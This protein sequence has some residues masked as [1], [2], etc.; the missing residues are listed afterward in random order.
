M[1]NVKIFKFLSFAYF[2]YVMA[3]LVVFVGDLQQWWPNLWWF[4]PSNIDN[5]K[6][7]L[8][9][10][11][12]T[13]AVIYDCILLGVF[14]AQH[15]GMATPEFKQWAS[16][17]VSP[18]LERS[19]YVLASSVV[20]HALMMFWIP[21]AQPILGWSF[22]IFSNGAFYA[23]MIGWGIMLASLATMD[24][25]NRYGV[26]EVFG[27]GQTQTG[28]FRRP[29]LH[30]FVRQP[31]FLGFL[32]G[33][34]SCA[35]MTHGHLLF[36]L[37]MTAYSIYGMQRIEK[38]LVNQYGERYTDFQRNTGLLFPR[39]GTILE[40]ATHAPPIVPEAHKVHAQ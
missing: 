38:G 21:I 37:A 4:F 40:R 3:W 17:Y 26:A 12:W 35:M 1:D 22:P 30:Q 11:N 19:S 7:P 28:E 10:Y 6:A 8:V 14:A 27:L 24:P 39:L 31:V 2:T 32:M 34:W 25:L 16:K 5:T 15:T 36:N 20:L 18:D 29:F 23:S 9:P 13:S 33:I